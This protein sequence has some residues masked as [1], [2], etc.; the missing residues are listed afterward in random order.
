[1]A[2]EDLLRPTLSGGEE[3]RAVYNSTGFFL[4]AFFG[5][6]VGAGIYGLANSQT[7]GRLRQDLPLI[8]AIVAA[9]FLLLVY[10]AARGGLEGLRGWLDLNL[11]D[12]LKILLRVLGLACFGA[13]YFMHRPYY[14][15]AQVAGVD[16]RPGWVPGIAALLLG[17]L[18]NGSLASWIQ[19]HH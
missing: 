11:T 13:I 5:G 1:M 19:G 8:V 15:S 3:P 7:L 2:D 14:R 12:T 10:A 9:C 18:A 6:P 17:I 16:S 4:S